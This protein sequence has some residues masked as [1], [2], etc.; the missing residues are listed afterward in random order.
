MISQK[1]KKYGNQIVPSCFNCKKNRRSDSSESSGDRNFIKGI[2]RGGWLV[3]HSV[4]H[5]FNGVHN[6]FSES[7]RGFVPGELVVQ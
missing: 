3:L 7:R 4:R 1:T 5:I 2:E 6:S